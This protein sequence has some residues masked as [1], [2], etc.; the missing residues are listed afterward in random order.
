MRIHLGALTLTASLILA[1]VTRAETSPPEPEMQESSLALRATPTVEGDAGAAANP[2]ASDLFAFLNEE[3]ERAVALSLAPSEL[4]LHSE[5]SAADSQAEV[6]QAEPVSDEIATGAVAAPIEIEPSESSDPAQAEPS[7]E[8]GQQDLLA[9]N[10]EPP[11]EA[12]EQSPALVD[13]DAPSLEGSEE[14]SLPVL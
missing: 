8:N 10:V 9:L 7:P 4:Q 6:A 1:P 5:G 11:A 3:N 2:S 14:P 13:Q 12:G